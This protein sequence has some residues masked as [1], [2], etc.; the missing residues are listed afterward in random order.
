MKRAGWSY[1]PSTPSKPPCRRPRYHYQH[2]LQNQHRHRQ[3]TTFWMTCPS[4][5]RPRRS[6]YYYLFDESL[7]S[8]NTVQASAQ[9][10]ADNPTAAP[11]TR[12]QLPVTR[13]QLPPAIQNSTT[14]PYSPTSVKHDRESSALVPN[15][16]TLT[17]LEE[18]VSSLEDKLAAKSDQI[19][20][21][22]VQISE[23]TEQ[24][25]VQ[26]TMIRS[27]EEEIG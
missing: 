25:L 10:P 12:P 15:D 24:P 8:E 27:L 23:Q 19:A 16:F 21:Q 11:V 5:S 14:P 22:N 3:C 2:Q 9:L 7:E 4:S 1:E 6:V 18:R 20:A 13:P 17:L 26:R